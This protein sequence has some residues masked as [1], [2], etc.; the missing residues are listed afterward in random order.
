[1]TAAIVWSWQDKIMETEKEE[2]LFNIEL[3]EE[4]DKPPTIEGYAANYNQPSE[5]MGFIEYIAPGAFSSAV[6]RDDVRALF[7]HDANYVLGRNRAGTLELVDDAVGLRVNITPPKAQWATDLMESMRRGDINQMSFAFGVF[8]E[9]W[10]TENDYPK[11]TIK[12]V[13]LYDVSVVT[14][15]AYPSTTAAVRSK[16]DELTNT[17][18]GDNTSQPEDDSVKQARNANRRRQ[19]D[20]L[21]RKI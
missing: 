16:L 15:P 1:M 6:G 11:R 10:D 14:Y 21:K 9:E 17:Q 12:D 7:N 13:K 8:D 19:L 2:R 3:R 20:L 5:D 4:A 18:A